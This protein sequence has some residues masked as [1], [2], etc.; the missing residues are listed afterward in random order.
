[1]TFIIPT[2]KLFRDGSDVVQH[3]EDPILF[4]HLEP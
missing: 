3:G 1:M 2:T 4:E